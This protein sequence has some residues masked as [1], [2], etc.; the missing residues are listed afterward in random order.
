MERIYVI[1]EDL[2]NH[3]PYNG[4]KDSAEPI[5]FKYTMDE[6][7]DACTEYE[8][9]NPGVIYYWREVLGGK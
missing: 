4:E 1:M 6:A 3:D 2:D 7:E 8:A 9:K 5:D